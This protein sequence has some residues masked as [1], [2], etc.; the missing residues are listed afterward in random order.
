ME[1]EIAKNRQ[2]PTGR[3]SLTFAKSSTKF[4]EHVHDAEAVAPDD[5]PYDGD[6]GNDAG[7]D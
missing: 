3:V 5:L 1:L 2:G 7:A 6:E 4:I